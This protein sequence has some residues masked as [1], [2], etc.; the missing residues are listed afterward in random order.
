[1]MR[2]VRWAAVA[3]LVV[4]PAVLAADDKQK[5][6]DAGTFV[7]KAASASM[8]EI[9]SSQ[10]AQ[11]KAQRAG[12]KQLA[13]H[14]IRDHTKANEELKA[15]ARQKNYTLPAQMD[16]QCQECYERVAN[17]RGEAFD[18]TFVQEQVKAHREAIKLFEQASKTLDDPELKAWAAKTLPTLKQHLR[19]AEALMTDKP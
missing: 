17:A 6:L 12:V 11:E 9:K 14:L 7:A 4:V 13:E 2:H 8:F 16:P 3:A 10:L 5:P 1:M 18:A 19:Q 15:I